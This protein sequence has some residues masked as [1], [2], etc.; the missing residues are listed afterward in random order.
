MPQLEITVLSKPFMSPLFGQMPANVRFQGVDVG[1]Y[2][3]RADCSACS[4][5][6]K[7]ER[8][9]AVADLHDVLPFQT[10]AHPVRLVRHEDLL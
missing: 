7:K 1:R 10:L 5:S 3:E 2:K 9:D 6:S 4:V 8:Y